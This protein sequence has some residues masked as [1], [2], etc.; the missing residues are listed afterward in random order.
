MIPN[1]FENLLT[2]RIGNSNINFY[3]SKLNQPVNIPIK[4]NRRIELVDRKGRFKRNLKNLIIYIILKNGNNSL[5]LTQ[6]R[7][8][9]N[10][11]KSFSKSTFRNNRI[12]LALLELAS[13]E[14]IIIQEDVDDKYFIVNT[15]ILVDFYNIVFGRLKKSLYDLF[16]PNRL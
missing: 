15:S 5:T 9:L 10:T 12:N 3:Y 11:I 1:Q 2:E 4:F 14:V 8:E 6:I 13:F 7:E 16:N